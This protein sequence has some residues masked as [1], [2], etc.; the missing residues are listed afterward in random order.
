L[1]TDT[2][3]PENVF[4][5]KPGHV[6]KRPFWKDPVVVIG[7][8]GPVAVLTGFFS[9]LWWERDNRLF[10]DKVYS[11]KANAD[12]LLKDGRSDEAYEAYRLVGEA[13][14]RRGSTDAMLAATGGDC[15]R[16]AAKLEPGV[17]AARK[18]AEEER[19]AEAER[20]RVKAEHA[21]EVARL[22]G[23]KADVSGDV[24]VSFSSGVDKPLRGVEVFFIPAEVPRAKLPGTIQRITELAK[25]LPR[26]T[27]IIWSI[28]KK[29]D[30]KA[31]VES[32][33]RQYDALERQVELT[34]DP[35]SPEPLNALIVYDAARAVQGDNAFGAKAVVGDR[36][37]PLFLRESGAQSVNTDVRGHYSIEGLTG[38]SYYVYALY[39]TDGSLIEWMAPLTVDKAGPLAFDLH[40]NKARLILNDRESKK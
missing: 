13:V 34:F 18:A 6:P 14:A 3:E 24:W 31:E 25:V 17:L 33:V 15:R 19:A 7:A 2:S 12:Q 36:V 35:G 21:A 16:M 8:I 9:Y 10:R 20:A 39:Y 30:E 29:E 26:L 4:E 38:G 11:W 27:R 1:A 23:L 40:N 28:K 22:A 37:M 5:P 32:V